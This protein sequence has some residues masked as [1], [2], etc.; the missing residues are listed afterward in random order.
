MTIETNS[1]LMLER[2]LDRL[3]K[4]DFSDE[5]TKAFEQLDLFLRQYGEV[6]LYFAQQYLPM[7]Y[8]EGR[9]GKAQLFFIVTQTLE[10]TLPVLAENCSNALI[11]IYRQSEDEDILALLLDVTI[12]YSFYELLSI[13]S[14][15][16]NIRFQGIFAEFLLDLAS[17]RSQYRA[18]LLQLSLRKYS[19]QL[20]QDADITTSQELP[21]IIQRLNYVIVFLL[22]YENKEYLASSPTLKLFTF[23][24]D[25]SFDKYRSFD[26]FSSE[27]DPLTY[28]EKLFAVFKVPLFPVIQVDK[29]EF[30]GNRLIFTNEGKG[31]LPFC[32]ISLSLLDRAYKLGELQRTTPSSNVGELFVDNGVS[33]EDFLNK[34]NPNTDIKVVFEFTK[35]GQLYQYSVPFL[36][37]GNWLEEIRR[38]RQ[39][40]G[41][42]VQTVVS[43]NNNTVQVIK[44]ERG[45]VS[46][47]TGGNKTPISDINNSI[48]T[49]NS[50]LTRVTQQIQAL[51]FG[52]NDDAR[53]KMLEE[54]DK[55]SKALEQ[56]S[57]KQQAATV[58]NAAEKLVET[59]S[60]PSEDKDT[61]EFR[62]NKLKQAAEN[63][64]E[65]LPTVLSISSDILKYFLFF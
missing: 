6:S 18:K 32:T 23:F 11:Q 55:L 39:A 20:T 10:S 53:Q 48:V 50:T 36:S 38:F 35:F 40:Q 63:I 58:A 17:V 2:F 9:Q 65:A 15:G 31:C 14:T 59:V 60:D 4:G 25:L 52:V 42:D 27:L 33:L 26:L 54:V 46:D 7:L 56:V 16:Q 37:T 45:N 29:I 61:V 13:E 62:G 1:K 43:G 22:K 21:S 47:I 5:L 51:P 8:G 3:R 34:L 28:D 64:K 30:L 49:V 44:S 41:G 24:P 57:D 12:E 19:L